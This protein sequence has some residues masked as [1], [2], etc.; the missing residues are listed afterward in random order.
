[1]PPDLAISILKSSGSA[2]YQKS[3][4]VRPLPDETPRLDYS[5]PGERNPY[6]RKASACEMSEESNV[7]TTVDILNGFPTALRVFDSSPS[8]PSSRSPSLKVRRER[9]FGKHVERQ[10]SAQRERAKSRERSPVFDAWQESTFNKKSGTA[11]FSKGSLRSLAG[12]DLPSRAKDLTAEVA[13]TAVDRTR[14]S[15][16]QGQQRSEE[17]V[18]VLQDKVMTSAR[19]SHHGSIRSSLQQSSSPSST[20]AMRWREVNMPSP[21]QSTRST[22]PSPPTSPYLKKRDVEYPERNGSDNPAMFLRMP[23]PGNY[24]G[25]QPPEHLL[26]PLRPSVPCDVSP[27]GQTPEQ[28]LRSAVSHA[29]DITVT[30]PGRT[31]ENWRGSL[32]LSDITPRGGQYSERSSLRSAATT[33][34]SPGPSPVTERL[35]SSLEILQKSSPTPVPQMQ[36]IKENWTRSNDAS[37]LPVPTRASLTSHT[38]RATPTPLSSPQ[39][40]SR[41]PISS[42]QMASRSI[43]TRSPASSPGPSPPVLQMATVVTAQQLASSK[44]PIQ[45]FASPRQ[46]QYNGSPRL[47]PSMAAAY[48]FTR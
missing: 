7:I 39:M 5:P 19:S 34:T 18:K 4:P 32:G 12:Y 1:M 44:P 9:S 29:S 45:A 22:L 26:S 42:P 47:P 36:A 11:A 41:S 14:F 8:R 13:P 28:R 20:P 27:P 46:E 6:T 33:V 37:P 16:L 23:V 17:E 35:R 3:G 31:P 30:P 2:H 38:P 24:P 25:G 40:A 43:G 48:Q 10:R 21:S 15:W